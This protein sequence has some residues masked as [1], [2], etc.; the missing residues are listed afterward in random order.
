[1]WNDKLT[2]MAVLVLSFLLTACVT[3]PQQPTSDP[4]PPVVSASSQR[5]AIDKL[6]VPRRFK[7]DLLRLYD[8]D[9]VERAWAAYQLAKQGAAA[10]PAVPH[11]VHLLAD[12]TEVLMSRYIGGGFHSSDAT[13]PADE[14]ARALAKIGIPSVDAL[15]Q[16]LKDPNPKVR[17]LAAK[18]LGQTG[19]MA[20]VDP[21]LQAVA[22][23]DPRVR[24]AATIALGSLHHP[25]VAQKLIDAYASVPPELQPH[26]IFA[27]SQINDIIV[28]P[29]LLEH[30]SSSSIETRAAIVLALGKLRDARAIDTLLMALKDEDEIVRANAAF[31]LRSFYSVTVMDAL[32][33]LLDDDVEGVRAAA[34]E[35]LRALSGLDYGQD[36]QQWHSWWQQQQRAIQP[37][38]EENAGKK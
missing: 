18:A 33:A 36:K 4:E 9:P 5:D 24:A 28:V 23:P 21:L 19:S 32:L 31:A 14:A 15:S 26:L 6:K 13:T 11:L 17:R 1:M 22:D 10:A 34:G 27:M 37:K 25:V 29:F 38:D 2:W 16:S 7:D 35:S 20:T 8:D 30:F 12:D 3:G